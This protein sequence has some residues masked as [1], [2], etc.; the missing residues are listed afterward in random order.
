[1]VLYENEETNIGQ[2]PIT[3]T[4]MLWINSYMQEK[5]AEYVKI[6]V[7]LFPTRPSTM[8]D[9]SSMW[10]N[11]NGERYP[12]SGVMG[13]YDRMFKRRNGIFPH[14]KSEQLMYY[15]YAT[16]SNVAENMIATSE[17]IYRLFDNE[18]ESAEDINTWASSKS[19]KVNGVDLQNKFYFHRFK[20]YQ[21][22]EV[23]DVINFGTV[24]TYAGSKMIVDYDYHRIA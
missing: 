4:P 17:I 14:I 1:M 23:Q 18:D 7:P 24:R 11:I 8:D 22:E 16:E 2:V 12:Y 20:V 21:L 19:I 5:L 3:N 10:I 9:I 13:V 15:F 6:A